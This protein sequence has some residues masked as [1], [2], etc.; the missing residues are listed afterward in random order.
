MAVT[1]Y[2]NPQGLMPDNGYKPQGFLG[3]YQ[4][5][6]QEQN[7]AS[8]M[9][10]SN[11]AQQ[12]AIM[13][14][15]SE[16]QDYQNEAPVRDA[17]R[18]FELADYGGQTATVPSKYGAAQAENAAT[19]EIAPTKV[20]AAKF[21]NKEARTS[22][23]QD[24]IA[25][26][27]TALLSMKGMDPASKMQAWKT[28]FLPKLKE[29]FG[30]KGIP[31][32]LENPTEQHLMLANQAA[33]QG[34]KRRDAMAL[35]G[36]KEAGDTERNAATNASRERI[37]AT[38]TDGRVTA[39]GNRPLSAAQAKQARFENYRAALIEQYIEDGMDP[40]AAS[41]KATI[42]ASQAFDAGNPAP[43]AQAAVEVDTAKRQAALR[44]L[45][46]VGAK[47]FPKNDKGQYDP[48]QA[49]PNTWYEHPETGEPSY[50][51]GKQM[52]KWAP[53]KIEGTVP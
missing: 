14:Q 18:K 41:R 13:K 9:G 45:K 29:E 48:S 15:Q 23:E 28:V 52:H 6:N 4:Y 16:Y 12:L 47:K 46:A 38:T 20:E 53:S 35:Q 19:A 36:M 44:Q 30:D 51:D 42:Q 26:Y 32:W 5:A 31:P 49:K 21:K 37:A 50:W 8:Q 34:R 25:D 40:Q 2:S 33:I 17:K 11:I 27:T 22:A 7:F 24:R 1:N 43:K 39:A 3:G 10:M